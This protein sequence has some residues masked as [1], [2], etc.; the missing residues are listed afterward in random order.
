MVDPIEELPFSDQWQE[1]LSTPPS[2]EFPSPEASH[3]TD[4]LQYLPSSLFD[5]ISQNPTSNFPEFIEIDVPFPGEIESRSIQ[6]SNIDPKSTEI[7]LRTIAQTFGE[8]E[9]L[10]PIDFFWELWSFNSMI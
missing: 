10:E 4:F 1:Y 9:H 5:D 7:E 6:I 8:I 2:W 3:V